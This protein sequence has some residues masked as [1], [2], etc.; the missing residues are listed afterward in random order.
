[1]AYRLFFP[2]VTDS[3]NFIESYEIA[4]VP[5]VCGI[6]NN[7]WWHKHLEKLFEEPLDALIFAENILNALYADEDCPCG[8]ICF[9]NNKTKLNQE[10]LDIL[11]SKTQEEIRND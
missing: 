9:F 11:R 10:M 3:E 7:Q 8:E 5:E 4:V 6:V 1:M 2:M